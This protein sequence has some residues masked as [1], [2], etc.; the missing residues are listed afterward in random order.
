[1]SE[2]SGGRPF[3]AAEVLAIPWRHTGQTSFH[4]ANMRR[5]FISRGLRSTFRLNGLCCFA[6]YDLFLQCGVYYYVQCL[7]GLRGLRLSFCFN[8]LYS[9]DVYDVF[10]PCLLVEGRS[11]LCHVLM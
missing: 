7:F 5:L 6:I 2:T 8:E 9:F 10:L 4:L 3:L 11:V 1:M